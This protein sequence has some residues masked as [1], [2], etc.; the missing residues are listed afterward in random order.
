MHRLPVEFVRGLAAVLLLSG[1]PALAL[2]GDRDQPVQVSADSARFSEKTGVATYSGT[3]VIRQG[4][5]EIRADVIVVTTDRKG[6]IV[7]TVATGNPARYQQQTDPR[8]GPV[9]AEADRIDYDARTDTIVLTG[10]ARLQQDGSSFQG[11]TITYNSARQ[12]IDARGDGSNRVQ[13][14]LPPQAREARPDR[15]DPRK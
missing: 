13:L 8:R 4:T 11:N 9:N 2:P 6:G 5:L 7:N 14:V 12:Q 15:K 1:A 3:V 10:K